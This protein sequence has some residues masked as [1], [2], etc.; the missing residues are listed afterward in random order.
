M[1]KEII[2]E[3]VEVYGKKQAKKMVKKILTIKKKHPNVLF[4]FIFDEEGNVQAVPKEVRNE[5]ANKNIS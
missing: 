1:D 4:S 3:L 2:K 5:D